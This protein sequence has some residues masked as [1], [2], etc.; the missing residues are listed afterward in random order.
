[1]VKY[2]SAGLSQVNAKPLSR[3]NGLDFD[4]ADDGSKDFFIVA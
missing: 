2:V 1:M 4:A 3:L